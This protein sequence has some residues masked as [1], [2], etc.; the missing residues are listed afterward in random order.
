MNLAFLKIG[1][2]FRL[3]SIVSNDTIMS[4]P[5]YQMALMI[6]AFEVPI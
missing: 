5:L 3:I 4:K 1:A 2:G 6:L